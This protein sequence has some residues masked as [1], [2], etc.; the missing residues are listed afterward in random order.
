MWAEGIASAQ[1]AVG[2]A[3]RA[4]AS[5]LALPFTAPMSGALPLAYAG[6]ETVAASRVQNNY[7][8]VEGLIPYQDPLTIPRQLQRF[9]EAGLFDSGLMDDE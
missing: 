8:T 9:G 4:L 3:S 5:G 6:A 7:V 2:D 1:G